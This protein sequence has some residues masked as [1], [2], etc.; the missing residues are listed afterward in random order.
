[1]KQVNQTSQ[2]CWPDVPNTTVCWSTGETEM[3]SGEVNRTIPRCGDNPNVSV[4]IWGNCF[5]QESNSKHLLTTKVPEGVQESS[6]VPTT[7]H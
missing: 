1:M 2:N 3:E 7:G 6:T 4:A 5:M